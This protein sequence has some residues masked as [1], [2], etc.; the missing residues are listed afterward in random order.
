MD[1]AFLYMR[2]LREGYVN[3][4]LWRLI[5]VNGIGS[6][7]SY[8]N[9]S[10]TSAVKSRPDPAEMFSKVDTDGSGGISQ[11]ELESLVT[12]MSNKTGKNVDATGAVSTYDTDGSD[13]LS[14]DELKSFM[15]ATMPPPGGV[16]R[17]GGGHAH[18]DPFSAIDA[19]SSGG[20]S[21]SEL[22]T[23]LADFSSKTGQGV[24]STDAVSTYDTDR[25][26]ELS[27]DELKSFMDASDIAPPPPPP[28]GPGMMK[29][30]DNSGTSSTKRADSVIS[31]YD[32]NSDGM[33]SSDELQ[34]YLDETET[35]SSSLMISLIKQAISAYSSNSAGSS[36]FDIS[37]T[38]L[39][40][41]ESGDYS[42]V[43]LAV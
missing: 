37:E 10:Q 41:Y 31:A 30:A 36:L 5:M 34:G 42:P 29:D 39:S 23:F 18:E 38:Y 28:G 22:E 7:F 8:L 3:L 21:Q 6:N 43:D 15:E 35:N 16:K 40:L 4:K 24:D 2:S 25:S 12:N 1:F 32:T 26:G 14:Q 27:K 17:M 13:E 20:V 11:T 19:D 33:L 9:Y